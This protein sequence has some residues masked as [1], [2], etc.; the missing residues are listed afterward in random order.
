MNIIVNFAI[1]CSENR[2]S[3]DFS[4]AGRASLPA[5]AMCI[6]ARIRLGCQSQRPSRSQADL[7]QRKSSSPAWFYGRLPQRKS[8][9][10]RECDDGA[11][12]FGW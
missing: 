1:V 11:K 12:F 7:R 2:L 6:Q 4:L 3:S 9:W 10:E 5:F 8:E